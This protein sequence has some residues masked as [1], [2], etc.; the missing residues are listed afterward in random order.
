MTAAAQPC[1]VRR[2]LLSG[3]E[4]SPSRPTRTTHTR[5][6]ARHMERQ[7][8][9]K[10][11]AVVPARNAQFP[12]SRMTPAATKTPAQTRQEFIFGIIVGPV[13]HHLTLTSPHPHIIP[14]FLRPIAPSSN[15]T[16]ISSSN[17]HMSRAPE[18][19]SLHNAASSHR[20]IA[21]LSHRRISIILLF[22]RHRI[23]RRR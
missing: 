2:A 14:C 7:R 16:I 3:V 10:T 20:R 21:P 17:R 13:D 1:D 11:A 9:T 15:R 23:A 18:I 22:D 5:C 8:P 4:A 19:A 12:K 6:L